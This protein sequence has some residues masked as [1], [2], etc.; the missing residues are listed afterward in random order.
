MKLEWNYKEAQYGL[1]WLE[2]FDNNNKTISKVLLKDCQ[3]DATGY[4][5]VIHYKFSGITICDDISLEEAM[6]TVEDYLKEWWDKRFN[7]AERDYLEAMEIV[8]FLK[9]V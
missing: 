9:G 4:N 2:L 1:Y 8:E 3:H 5:G 7:T 6:I